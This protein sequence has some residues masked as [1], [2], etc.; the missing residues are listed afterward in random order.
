MS[1]YGWMFLVIG[2]FALAA[3]CLETD[4][5]YTLNPDK[6]GKVVLEFYLKPDPLG[7]EQDKDSQAKV[8]KAASET[9]S[10]SKGIETWKNVSVKHMD[11]GRI[12][13]KGTAYFK[14]LSKVRAATSP[15]SFPK[16]RLLRKSRP[17][18]RCSSSG[19]P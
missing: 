19:S 10:E 15:P 11:D 8:K 9:L 7:M 3:G 17:R 4:E 12:H 13:F 18:K 6:S 1:K 16:R 5:E 14:D 2:I